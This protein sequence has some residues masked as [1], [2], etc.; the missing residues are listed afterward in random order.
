[1]KPKKI[2][3]IILIF[4][5][6]CCNAVFAEEY[7]ANYR[8]TTTLNIR[9]GPGKSYYK[10]GQFNEGDI[11][12]VKSVTQN[13][14]TA[15]GCIDF[16]TVQ[17]GYVAMRYLDYIGTIQETHTE[18]AQT[19]QSS[20]FFDWFDSIFDGLG[21]FLSGL[22]TLV[23]WGLIII[24]V[25]LVL[26]FREEIIQA[27]VFLGMFTGI[28]A[29]IFWLLFDNSS[30]GATIGFITGILIGLRVF[31]QSIDGNFFSLFL[32]AYWGITIPS[33][34]CN[35]LQ[36]VLT[37]PWRYLF[38]YISV[39]DSTRE[40]LRPFFYFIQILLYIATTPLRTL[41]AIYYNI[42][43]YGIT[44]IYDLICEVFMP[45]NYSEGR[46][47]FWKWIIY[48]PVRL[49]RYPVFHG[50]L[51]LIEGAVWTVIDIIIPTITMYH[52][53]NIEA[54][55]A[56][57]GSSKRNQ[58]LWNQWLSGTFMASNSNNAWGGMGVYFAPS[59]HIAMRYC[60]RAGGTV[61]IA[62]RVS[63]GKIL[64]YALAPRYVEVNTGGRG[65]PSVLN[66]YAESN[67][68]DTAEWWNGDYW[69]YCM[70]DWQN[71]YNK[72]WRIRPIYAFNIET[73]LAQHIDGGF[74]HWLFSKMVLDD[75]L[76]SGRFTALVTFAFFVVI[77]CVIWLATNWH[78]LPLP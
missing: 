31:L 23:K 24:V 12:V 8:V 75:I 73:G 7:P 68:Y 11:I 71:R 62:C 72:P 6:G 29:L 44:E 5:I 52:G 27:A 76:N 59:R 61:F 2:I 38:K 60:R 53:T 41:N 36:F 17:E 78:Y 1:M 69:E 39:D 26:A 25:L 37:G 67:G 45:S 55:N 10:L 20:G 51:A 4:I 18:P 22:W 42:F 50:T 40:V 13:G 70:F 49:V 74:R 47:D 33:W 58:N 32:I 46:G 63:L 48:F 43:V 35:R 9:S 21:S 57:L 14:S 54:A 56:I 19:K 34:I 30:L 16:T 28:G 66:N 65:C 64:N 77:C 15:W 3:L